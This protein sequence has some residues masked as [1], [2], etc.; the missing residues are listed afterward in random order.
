MEV[1]E[2]NAGN[3]EKI[4]HVPGPTM[5]LRRDREGY[6][7]LRGRKKKY[8][9]TINETRAMDANTGKFPG[10]EGFPEEGLQPEDR[11]SRIIHFKKYDPSCQDYGVPGHVAAAPAIAGNRLSAARNVEF[12]ENDATPR[13][14]IIVSGGK[15]DAE[16]VDALQQMLVKGHKGTRKAHRAAVLQ[17]EPHG[18][19]LDGSNPVKIEVIPL[20]VGREEDASFLKYR[21]AND[22]EI[23]EALGLSKVFFTSDDVN[24]ASA[25][26]GLELTESQEFAPERSRFEHIVNSQL[27]PRL[28]AVYWTIRFL[29]PELSNPQFVTEDTNTQSEAGWISVNEARAKL[30]M[31]PLPEG[32]GYGWALLPFPLVMKLLEKDI[33]PCLDGLALLEKQAKKA[34]TAPEEEGG[35]EGGGEEEGEE[36]APPEGEEGEEGGEGGTA[37]EEEEEEEEEAP[38]VEASIGSATKP[39]ARANLL[40]LG[41]GAVSAQTPQGGEPAAT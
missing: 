34:L 27:F 4:Y 5:R 25:E 15:L 11:A 21:V 2:D 13:L 12:F 18:L 1:V 36:T 28:N 37:P 38:P 7:Q 20:T 10:E 6:V 30:G 26:V 33:P 39:G 31:D 23:R 32:P 14:L 3:I 41:D 17:A 40:K 29:G 19:K 8:F 24:R 35:E 22:E 9:R 16:S